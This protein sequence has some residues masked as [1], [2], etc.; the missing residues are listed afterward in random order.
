MR[1]KSE[2]KAGGGV[3]VRP[4]QGS[5][6]NR[7]LQ[8]P[9]AVSGRLATSS[10]TTARMCETKVEEKAARSWTSIRTSLDRFGRKTRDS[11]IGWEGEKREGERGQGREGEMEM[12]IKLW[13]ASIGLT[14]EGDGHKEGRG[15]TEKEA[16]R[17]RS[18]AR[19]RL[20]KLTALPTGRQ[21]G[22]GALE[23]CATCSFRHL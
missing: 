5:S 19:E 15:N 6:G 12:S 22:F 20:M 11:E 13:R 9:D 2:S 8:W 4:T 23:L 10:E 14:A 17:Q 21:R 7:G 1:G 3:A 16:R 18:S